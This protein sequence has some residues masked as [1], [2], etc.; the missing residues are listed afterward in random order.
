MNF[1]L[2]VLENVKR[3]ANLNNSLFTLPPPPAV[4]TR[5]FNM[6]RGSNRDTVSFPQTLVCFPTLTHSAD[7]GPEASMVSIWGKDF[8][9][10][11]RNADTTEGQFCSDTLEEL[12]G[13]TACFPNLKQ[14]FK[15]GLLAE[16]HGRPLKL[17]PTLPLH[18]T[19]VLELSSAS[20]L[21]QR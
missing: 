19:V 7:F 14:V 1:L 13:N 11:H 21:P 9:G 18:A 10:L 16:E 15:S 8:F 5:H 2:V 17:S 20:S 4:G 6:Y 3:N 12:S